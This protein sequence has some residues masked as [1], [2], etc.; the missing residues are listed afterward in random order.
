[1]PYL[2]KRKEAPL[3]ELRNLPKLRTRS[4]HE[5]LRKYYGALLLFAITALVVGAATLLT[6]RI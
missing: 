1:M 6:G 3:A 4:R 5:L 2:K